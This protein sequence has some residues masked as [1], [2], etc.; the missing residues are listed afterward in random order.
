MSETIHYIPDICS[1]KWCR[2]DGRGGKNL[3][4]CTRISVWRSRSSG[5]EKKTYA[6]DFGTTSG[7]KNRRVW[8]NG[9]CNPTKHMTAKSS[10]HMQQLETDIWLCWVE[11]ASPKN[12]ALTESDCICAKKKKKKNNG[13]KPE[14]IS[15]IIR[16]RC[17]LVSVV[18]AASCT[19]HKPG[20]A[21]KRLWMMQTAKW[22]CCT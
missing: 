22:A 10:S 6:Q 3:K 14:K 13:K 21:L 9:G 2:K 15:I 8:S 5:L 1:I 17:S 4:E 20:K 18:R 16:L 12:T 11:G 7:Q 19:C